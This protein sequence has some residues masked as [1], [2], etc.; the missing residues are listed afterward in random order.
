MVLARLRANRIPGQLPN[1]AESGRTPRRGL[2]HPLWHLRPIADN[3]P[4][5][6]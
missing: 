1:Y 2:S 6:R 3:F 4:D 5:L